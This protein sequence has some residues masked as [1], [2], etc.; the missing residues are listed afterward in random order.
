MYFITTDNVQVPGAGDVIIDSTNGTSSFIT[1]PVGRNVADTLRIEL[2]AHAR[3][4]TL[5]SACSTSAFPTSFEQMGFTN[6]TV[7]AS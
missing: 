6:V 5:I 1:A 3:Y 7:D 4:I 2:D